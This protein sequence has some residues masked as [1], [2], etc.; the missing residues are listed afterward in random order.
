MLLNLYIAVFAAEPVKGVAY[1][2]KAMSIL[3]LP[4]LFQSIEIILEQF[5]NP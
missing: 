4:P 5:E 2:E 3:P 1:A